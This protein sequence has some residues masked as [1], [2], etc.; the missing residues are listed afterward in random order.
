M[1]PCL[2]LWL[3]YFQSWGCRRLRKNHYE[4]CF[5]LDLEHIFSLRTLSA[6]FEWMVWLHL[7]HQIHFV[8]WVQYH[9]IQRN[10]ELESCCP[11][12]IDY[13]DNMLPLICFSSYRESFK[14]RV[15]FAG[16][17][18]FPITLVVVTSPASDLLSVIFLLLP[19]MF[20][21]PIEICVSE[22]WKGV[23]FGKTLKFWWRL[24]GGYH[25]CYYY[26]LTH[27]HLFYV[28]LVYELIRNIYITESS[29]YC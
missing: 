16:T 7:L 1:L 6:K 5:D 25:I 20:L 22:N 3:L 8:S 29:S 28:P 21:T 11:K 26:S 23:G 10:Q 14:L 18:R 27:S 13:S 15:F 17:L 24:K 2:Q 19:T 4:L 12:S 9:Q